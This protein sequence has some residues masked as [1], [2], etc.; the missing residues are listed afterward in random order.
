MLF[1]RK[2]CDS[3]KKDVAYFECPGVD[4][5]IPLL[6]QEGWA[7]SGEGAERTAPKEIEGKGYTI[8]FPDIPRF[9]IEDF[10][11]QRAVG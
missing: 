8:T 4:E 5:S 7:I 11:L 2:E 3:D 9:K 1:I 10:G 6:E